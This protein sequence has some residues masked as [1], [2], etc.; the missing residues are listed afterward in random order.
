MT[1]TCSR[2]PGSRAF[3]PWVIP[4]ERRRSTSRERRS[5]PGRRAAGGAGPRLAG[6]RGRGDQAHRSRPPQ[7]AS[8][9]GR[10]L[11]RRAH[12]ERISR[13]TAFG[14]A[15]RWSATIAT[16]RCGGLLG[17]RAASPRW[18]CPRPAWSSPR[19]W[20][21]WSWRVPIP[22]GD[23]HDG[24][25]KRGDVRR[26]RCPDLRVHVAVIRAFSLDRYAQSW[27]PTIFREGC[28]PF[29]AWAP[30]TA[31]A[32]VVTVDDVTRFRD[33]HQVESYVGP[34]SAGVA[35]ARRSDAGRSPTPK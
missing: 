12:I 33:A 20:P 29:P 30:V 16:S 34:G 32:F 2:S 6:R 24:D 23:R 14:W 19:C 18:S 28:A 25:R 8:A 15:P 35:R 26:S 9:R 27:P 5:P 21:A 7:E 3:L 22:L 13:R 11:H 10:A 17:P 31:V 4:A 1:R